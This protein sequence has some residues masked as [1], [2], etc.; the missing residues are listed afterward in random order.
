M[1]LGQPSTSDDAIA[2]A[3]GR[4]AFDELDHA[5]QRIATLDWRYS[6][7]GANLCR[8]AFATSL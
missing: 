7:D 8:E 1:T 3:A 5:S 4:L 6:N 2:L